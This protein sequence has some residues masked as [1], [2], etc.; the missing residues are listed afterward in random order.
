MTGSA[1]GARFFK[2]ISSNRQIHT[3]LHFLHH[4]IG[5]RLA[6][7]GDGG[8]K[9]RQEMPVGGHVGDAGFDE[10]VEAAGDEVAFENVWRL[11]DGGGE[12]VENVG[13]GARSSFTSTNNSSARSSLA[14]ERRAW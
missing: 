14:G 11:A 12:G 2:L 10:V 13:G 8:E 1:E 3:L 9:P 5:P 4:R 7:A 6:H